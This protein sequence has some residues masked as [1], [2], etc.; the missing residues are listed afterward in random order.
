[1]RGTPASLLIVQK[2]VEL[3]NSEEPFGNMTFLL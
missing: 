1:L 2:T 3:V